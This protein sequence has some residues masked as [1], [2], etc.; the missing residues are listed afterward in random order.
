MVRRFKIPF[1]VFTSLLVIDVTF[2]ISYFYITCNFLSKYSGQFYPTV[3]V[4]FHDV[5]VQGEYGLSSVSIQELDVVVNLYKSEN[6]QEV[7]C[8][9][10]CT[11]RHESGSLLMKKYLESR[12]I[13]RDRII[14]DSLSFDTYTNWEEARRIIRA[15]NIQAVTLVSSPMH[16]YRIYLITRHD[17]LKLGFATY[18]DTYRKY[19]SVFTVWMDIQHE[20]V[21]MVI[22]CLPKGFREQVLRK[23]RGA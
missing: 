17:G 1:I 8:L 16:L 2:S 21:G 5:D 10:G 4:F 22:L 15:N 6:V 12:G 18:L 7:I 9:G 3:V 11:K 23:Y 20:F 13:V 14:R 19:S